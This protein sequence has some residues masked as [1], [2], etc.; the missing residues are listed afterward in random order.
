MN[1]RRFF[2]S[3]IKKTIIFIIH[4]SF[5]WKYCSSTTGIIDTGLMGNLGE[6][7][8]LAATSVATSV[9]TMIIWSF[10]FL[11]MGTVGIVAQLYGK[12][13]YREIVKTLSRNFL[14]AFILSVIIILFKPF[15]LN[16]INAFFSTSQETQKLNKNLYISKS[17]FCA[18]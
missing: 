12:S 10:G 1:I 14:I 18:R 8:Y 4:S 11:R 6:T 17:F 15:I 7:K 13:D 5:L 3:N 9:M 16:L 2:N